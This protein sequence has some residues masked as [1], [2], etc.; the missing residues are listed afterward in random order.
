MTTDMDQ[1]RISGQI[2]NAI[3]EESGLS[4]PKCEEIAF[5]MT[6]WLD[7]FSRLREFYLPPDSYST[8]K[9]YSLVLEFLIHAQEHIAAASDL[10]T[11]I[12]VERIFTKK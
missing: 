12:P 8:D 1:K 6:D 10:L 2:A 5:H 11:D 9:I 3:C 7:E 4:R